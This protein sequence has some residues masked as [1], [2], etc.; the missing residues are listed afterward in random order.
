QE[1]DVSEIIPAFADENW[2]A[3]LGGRK[4]AEGCWRLI[5][6]YMGHWEMRGY[7]YWALEDKSTARLLGGAGLW[8]SPQW[9]A[10]ELGYWILPAYQR[11]GYAMEACQH[12]LESVSQ[13]MQPD[14]LVSFI[15]PDNQP[16]QALA[17][18]LGG[19]KEAAIPLLTFGP[20]LVFRYW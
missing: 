9:P 18:R 7:G 3:Y 10:L 4:D 12:I 14:S 11:Q 2:S 15:H 16:S 20:H 1:E 13:E 5:A 6:G 8:H 19:K 17:L